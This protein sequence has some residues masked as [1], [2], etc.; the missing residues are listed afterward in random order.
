MD[1][2]LQ[3]NCFIKH[4]VDTNYRQPL[5]SGDWHVGQIGFKRKTSLTDKN[6]AKKSENN[7]LHFFHRKEQSRQAVDNCSRSFREVKNG[8]AC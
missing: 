4:A 3:F 1:T 5:H 7:V 6:F 8:N 2:L